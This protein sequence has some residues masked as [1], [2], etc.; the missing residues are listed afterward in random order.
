[1][2]KIL[3]ANHRYKIYPGAVT[4]KTIIL[5]LNLLENNSQLRGVILQVGLHQFSTQ[6][7]FKPK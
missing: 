4:T 6:I 7:A 3:S 5:K 2:V 1:M